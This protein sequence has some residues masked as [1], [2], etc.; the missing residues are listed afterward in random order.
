MKIFKMRF[1][2][3]LNKELRIESTI[4]HPLPE[5]RGHHLGSRF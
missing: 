1:R 4:T 2:V 3:L 5:N